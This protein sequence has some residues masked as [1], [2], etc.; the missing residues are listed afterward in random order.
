LVYWIARPRLLAPAAPAS[1][2]TADALL[3]SSGE[4]EMPEPKEARRLR[5]PRERGVSI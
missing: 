5:L 1:A 2:S 3:V 4:E